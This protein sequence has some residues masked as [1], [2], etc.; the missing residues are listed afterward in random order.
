[1]L[2]HAQYNNKVKA[3]CI[4][5]L[6]SFLRSMTLTRDIRNACSNQYKWTCPSAGCQVILASPPLGAIAPDVRPH[7]HFVYKYTRGKR[8]IGG[9]LTLVLRLCKVWSLK[10]ALKSSPSWTGVLDHA[11]SRVQMI[12]EVCSLP[13]ILKSPLGL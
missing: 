3:V 2:L 12:T 5:S 13:Q 6:D 4:T 8:A 1:M 9:G 11:L 10:L 7:G